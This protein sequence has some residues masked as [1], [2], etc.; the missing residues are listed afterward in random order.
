M[1]FILGARRTDGKI[2][3]LPHGFYRVNTRSRWRIYAIRRDRVW[4][5]YA[6]KWRILYIVFLVAI[7][8]AKGMVGFVWQEVRRFR[9]LGLH[10]R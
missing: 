10:H 2:R 6:T 5:F 4:V 1:R 7:V 9:R 8:D 3:R